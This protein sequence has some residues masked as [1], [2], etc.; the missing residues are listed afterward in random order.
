MELKNHRTQFQVHVFF[1]E[2]ESSVSAGSACPEKSPTK[3]DDPGDFT[4]VDWDIFR[5]TYY[6]PVILGI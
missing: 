4:L 2:W 1:F 6:Y 5:K 3:Q